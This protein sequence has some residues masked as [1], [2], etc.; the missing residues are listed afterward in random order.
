MKTAKVLAKLEVEAKSSRNWKKREAKSMIH[1]FKFMI[2]SEEFRNGSGTCSFSPSD[3]SAHSYSWYVLAK[4]MKGLNVLNSYVYSNQ[5]SKHI[6]KVRSAAR[7]LGLR[8]CEV[9]AP[10]GLQDL[11]TAL[12]HVLFRLEEEKLRLLHSRSPKDKS[13][14]RNYEAQLKLLERLGVRAKKSMKKDA[15]LR[16][17]ESREERLERLNF[18]RRK[19]VIEDYLENEKNFRDYEV[20]RASRY[21]E[22][23]ENAAKVLIEDFSD[24]KKV[25][26]QVLANFSSLGQ[27]T[28]NFY[29]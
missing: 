2:R 18:K 4:R 16:A 21:E 23:E 14:V 7:I 28:V 20:L 9:E 17:L 11:Q 12:V 1:G 10:K 3:F 29:V 6:G 15:A 26:D 19:K 8:Y 13:Q 22:E 27:G 24:A 5:T 25:I